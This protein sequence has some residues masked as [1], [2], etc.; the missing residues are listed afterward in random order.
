MWQFKLFP[1]LKHNYLGMKHTCNVL[2]QRLVNAEIRASDMYPKGSPHHRSQVKRPAAIQGG[3]HGYSPKTHN[4][5]AA[6][7]IFKHY[8]Y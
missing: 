4:L 5:Y 6:N 3:G 7:V 1:N 8:L 2:L